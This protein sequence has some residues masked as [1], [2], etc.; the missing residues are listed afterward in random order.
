MIDAPS[1]AL[2]VRLYRESLRDLGQV[3]RLAPDADL[4]A[5]L[6]QAALA[7]LPR[8]EGWAMQVLTVERTAEGERTGFLLDQLARREMGGADF[9]AALAATLDGAVAVLAVA[10]RDPKRIARLRAAL[11]GSK[12]G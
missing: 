2:R 5:A 7:A 9:A 8:V 12:P 4:R 11:A 10:A 3:Y 1:R 6:R